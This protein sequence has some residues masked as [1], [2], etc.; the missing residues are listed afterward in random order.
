MAAQ[1]HKLKKTLQAATLLLIAAS[2][3][4][5][6]VP[7]LKPG[8]YAIFDTSMGQITAQLYEK[9][10]PKTVTS[11]VGLAQGTKPWLDPKTKTM[12]TRPFYENLKFH[13]VLPEI[14][15]QSGSISGRSTDNCGVKVPDELMPGLTFERAGMLA[16]ANTGQ[17]NSGACQFFFTD[18]LMKQWNGKYTIFGRVVSGQDVIHAIN[19]LP[20]RNETPDKPAILKTVSIQRVEKPAKNK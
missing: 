18:E 3:V 10:A 5:A 17:P 20:S 11:F 1:P 2:A 19:R 8:L 4:S 15:I 14:M 7:E 9:E 12:V 16:M 13:R 6:Q